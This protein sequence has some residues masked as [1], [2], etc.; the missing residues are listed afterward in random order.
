[1]SADAKRYALIPSPASNVEKFEWHLDINET[2]K[3]IIFTKSP[4]DDETTWNLKRLA[5]LPRDDSLPDGLKGKLLPVA[6]AVSFYGTGR[7]DR[8]LYDLKR[9][10]TLQIH[11]TIDFRTGFADTWIQLNENFTHSISPDVYLKLYN[12]CIILLNGVLGSNISLVSAQLQQQFNDFFVLG[13]EKT[14]FIDDPSVIINE[15]ERKENRDWTDQSN[16]IQGVER[17]QE[18]LLNSPGFKSTVQYTSS[19]YVFPL[20][21]EIKAPLGFFNDLR[22]TTSIPFIAYVDHEGKAYIK[23]HTSLTKNLP[24]DKS[25]TESSNS[26]LFDVGLEGKTVRTTI[27]LTNNTVTFNSREVDLPKIF[28]ILRQ[29]L[30]ITLKESGVT[31]YDF[32]GTISIA[33]TAGAKF[34][35][36]SF[37]YSFIVDNDFSTFI[38]VNDKSSL[39]FT[40]PKIKLVYE[41]SGSTAFNLMNRTSIK[42]PQIVNLEIDVKTASEGS[43]VFKFTD[44]KNDRD[45]RSLEFILSKLMYMYQLDLD[46]K[47]QFFMNYL[48]VTDT[49]PVASSFT[50]LSITAPELFDDDYSKDV[51]KAA[52]W[53]TIITDLSAPWLGE[54]IRLVTPR[55]NVIYV[56]ASSPQYPYFGLKETKTRVVPQYFTKLQTSPSVKSAFNRLLGIRTSQPSTRVRSK[57]RAETDLLQHGVIG[58]IPESLSRFFNILWPEFSSFKRIGVTNQGSAMLTAAMFAVKNNPEP[59]GRG[60]TRI[61]S[62]A[63]GTFL[64]TAAAPSVAPSKDDVFR[65]VDQSPLRDI[66][67]LRREFGIYKLPAVGKQELY[68][69]SEAEILR[70]V[71]TLS[72]ILGPEYIRIFEELLN[73]NIILFHFNEDT[74]NVY[75]KPPRHAKHYISRF[76]TGRQTVILYEHKGV[77][78]IIMATYRTQADIEL[79]FTLFGSSLRLYIPGD[80]ATEDRYGKEIHRRIFNSVL[81]GYGVINDISPRPSMIMTYDINLSFLWESGNAFLSS[82]MIDTYGKRYGVVMSF[83]GIEGFFTVYHLPQEPLNVKTSTLEFEYNEAFLPAGMTVSAINSKGAWYPI[84]NLKLGFFVRMSSQGLEKLRKL[85]GKEIQPGPLPQMLPAQSP[86]L[87]LGRR[88]Q[89]IQTQAQILTRVLKWVW[90]RSAMNTDSF[91]EKFTVVDDRKSQETGKALDDSIRYDFTTLDATVPIV[92]NAQ[93]AIAYLGQKTKGLVRGA[94]IGEGKGDVKGFSSNEGQVLQLPGGLRSKLSTFLK[95]TNNGQAVTVFTEVF[96]SSSDFVSRP[97]TVVLTGI[98][99]YKRWKDPIRSVDYVIPYLYEFKSG[100]WTKAVI[101]YKSVVYY[102]SYI[103][104]E[105]KKEEAIK[106]AS[107][108]YPG[109]GY[110]ILMIT[111]NEFSVL[112]NATSGRSQFFTLVKFRDKAG[113]ALMSILFSQALL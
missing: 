83:A 15:I 54:R 44:A 31:R 99:D 7:T 97:N 86:T 3:V 28:E 33:L 56:S 94:P 109:V 41:P 95:N 49:L 68:D 76:K 64:G 18:K 108:R 11:F 24:S 75:V 36:R 101:L 10:I 111:N 37:L 29:S 66:A 39:Q 5:L 107:E 22:V 110:V 32:S 100:S 9:W 61:N 2:K 74:K 59:R 4:L 46:L 47:E 77:Y 62:S 113:Y 63:R 34:G 16:I 17:S 23:L 70:N 81:G 73:I 55:G 92:A 14:Q 52:R 67:T 96:R 30:K 85:V 42:T 91:V 98:D 6:T 21:S 103:T 48:G 20:L 89:M 8:Q 88:A 60:S 78:D 26:F 38:H 112:E 25:I 102:I 50:S 79:D 35:R 82:Q 104:T 84:Q 72:V 105:D 57:V 1:M 58:G 12:Y 69:L 90:Q 106:I 45:I 51:T 53:P 40:K 27:S 87:G 65:M 71:S 93:E 13:L 80:I 19:T 43:I